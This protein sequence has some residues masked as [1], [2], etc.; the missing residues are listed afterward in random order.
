MSASFTYDASENAVYWQTVRLTDE[1]CEKLLDLFEGLG[2]ARVF[3]ELYDQ[4]LKAGGIPRVT[5]RRAA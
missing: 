5:N 4:H 2:E 3:N 1:A